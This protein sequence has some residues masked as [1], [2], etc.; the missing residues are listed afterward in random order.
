M[1]KLMLI[2]G[3]SIMNRA[4]YAIPILTNK[5]GQYTN[6]IYGFL[7]I[8]FKLIEEEQPTYIG[9]SFDLPKPTFRH[10]K[11]S[12]YKGNRKKTPDELKSQIPLIK[13][14]LKTMNIII[15]EKEGYEADDVLATI[16]KKAENIGINPIIVSGDRD[17]LQVATD[18]IKIKIP[19]TK[20]GKTEI[21]DYFA[22]DVMEKYSVTPK[23]FI[24]VKALMGDTSDN[25]PGVPSI[26]EK[27]AIKIINEYKTVENAI[28]NACNIK[29]KKAGENILEYK[30][31]ALLSKYLVTID[32]NV[33]IDFLN[34]KTENIFNEEFF[35]QCKKYELKT[36]L[37]KFKEPTN[38]EET[39][40][41][42]LI[43]NIED[44]K[45]YFNNLKKDEEIA[46]KIVYDDN[47]LVG[48]GFT[49]KNDVG[50]FIKVGDNISQDEIL[51]IYKPFFEEDYKKITID[52]KADIIFLN[53][54][55]IKLNNLIF[56]VMIGAYILN[57]TKDKYEYNNIAE[58]I[59]DISYED[60]DEILGTKKSKKFIYDIEKETWFKYCVRQSY[61][62]YNSKDIISKNIEEN[63]QQE[64]FYNIE[65]PLIEV[66]A[67]MEI[68][69]IK[70]SKEELI[71]YQQALDKEI[72]QLTKEIHWIAG[73]EFNINS[74][75]QLGDILFEKL[76]LKG[77]KKTTR[78]WSTSADVLEKLYDQHEII[79]KIL[80]YRTYAKLKSTY[81]DGLLN[82]LD[83]KTSRIYSSF[84]Q[85]ATATGRISSTE[86]NLQNI[87]IKIELGHKVRKVFKPEKDYIFIDADYSQIELRVLAHL[88]K[89]EHLIQA[90]NEGQD[91]HKT[92]AAKVFKKPLEDVTSF[93]RSA[94]KAINFGLIYGKQAFSLAQDLGITKAKAEEYI[95]D[96]FDKYPKIKE[97]L[98]SIVESTKETGYT[99]TMFN[100]M[101]YVPEINSSNFMQR[102]V[103]QRIAMN[104]PIQGTAA[105]IIKIAM[106]KVYKRIKKENLKSRLILQV[107]DELLIE[108]YKDEKDTIRQILKD[109]MENAIKFSVKL[110]ID[111]NEGEN[112]YDTK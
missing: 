58:E 45:A 56:D 53:K 42:K 74:S 22:K 82:V 65:M 103:G 2:D 57:P 10:L 93:E 50:T 60:K 44:A 24:E 80:V 99:K 14:V 3:H 97:F 105:D 20:A 89:D 26:G 4:F 79:P 91:I 107:H 31:Q 78:G 104:T 75:K 90:F 73:E 68:Y 37:S 95:N 11:Y 46:Y 29:P 5:D 51:N 8:L 69:G 7:N 59:L 111:I 71:E 39:L 61:V 32:T 109:E 67:S 86:P 36:I 81:A 101:R 28:E 23:E 70:V 77:S 30:D 55:N 72:E 49:T 54:N 102:G 19:K 112:W 106:V 52:A 35:L 16:A 64:L 21:E 66:L 92:T 88:S 48:I 76:S 43:E 94:A 33:P 18:N 98:D 40:D 25:V 63:N 87:P 9:V 15:Y 110:L 12:H 85:T 6:A 34:E 27:T 108:A 47:I 13:E 38:T 84:N 1:E 62:A 41:F 83:E 96:Y 17:L 100:R